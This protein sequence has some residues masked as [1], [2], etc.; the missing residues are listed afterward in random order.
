MKI[1]VQIFRNNFG[2]KVIVDKIDV[3]IKFS[4]GE[5]EDG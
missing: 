5:N 2:I 3:G 1:G 4:F